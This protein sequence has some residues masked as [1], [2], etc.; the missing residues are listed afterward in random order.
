M[1]INKIYKLLVLLIIVIVFGCNQNKN[2]QSS[3]TSQFTGPGSYKILSDLN[4]VTIPFEFYDMNLMVDAEVNGIKIKMLVDNGVLWDELWFYGNDQV[5]SLNFQLQEET[6][7]TGT[8][9]GDGVKS[10]STSGITIAFKGIEFYE[11]E[12]MVSSK[13]QGFADYFPGIAGQVCGA[14]FK[15]FIVEFDFANKNMIL[16][17]PNEFIVPQAD[18]SEFIMTKDT[19][20]SYS[21]PI[22]AQLNED[23]SY[24]LNYFIDLG[25]IYPLSI[26][27]TKEE[28]KTILKNP[29]RIILGYGASGP[30]YG[31][32]DTADVVN[33]GG[34][35]F[36][37]IP[38]ILV[39]DSTGG[40]HTNK[41]IGLPL[42]MKQ[43]IIFDY[44]H[45]KIYVKN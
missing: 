7:I 37:N 35:T 9:E 25:G 44:F 31:Y 29:E 42:L 45:N 12:A 40:D 11:Q 4:T 23:Y 36:Y 21:I 28:V 17:K 8:G 2:T 6:L 43:R 10:Y 26:P 38:V 5:D 3:S 13:E 22:E 1:M 14:F 41:T 33:L 30:I 34:N 27:V 32:E 18:W 16:H 24:N 20:D 19:V 15:H 39:E